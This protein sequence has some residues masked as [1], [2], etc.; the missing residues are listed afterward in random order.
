MT[1][2]VPV[3]D[4]NCIRIRSGENSKRRID[5]SA[6]ALAEAVAAVEDLPVDEE[7]SAALGGLA[8][9]VAGRIC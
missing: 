1:S 3:C 2:I 9:F 8:V 4:A 5:N 7:V 6:L